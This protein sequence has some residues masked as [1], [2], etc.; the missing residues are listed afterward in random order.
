[1]IIHLALIFF[2]VIRNNGAL[3]DYS[4][5]CNETF[6]YFYSFNWAEDPQNVSPFAKVHFSKLFRSYFQQQ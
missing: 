3:N 4:I 5:Q 1:M 2:I 6:S